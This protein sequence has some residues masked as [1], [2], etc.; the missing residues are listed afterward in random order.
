MSVFEQTAVRASELAR[1]ARMAAYRGLG[2]TPREHDEQTRRYFS[3]GR[4]Y[5]HY[6]C[7][8]LRAKH[9]AENVEEEVEIEWPLGVGHADAYIIPAKLLVEIKSTVTP[10]TSSP[11][12]EMAVAQL[13]IYLRYHPEAERG[14]L[15]LLNPSD[16]RG[17]DVFQ[18][19]LIEEDRERI[20]AAVAAVRNALDGG[21]LPPRVCSRPGQARGRLCPFAEPC[22]EDWAPPAPSLSS[23]PEVLEVVTRLVAIKAEERTHKQAVQGLAAGKELAQSELAELLPVGETV[24]GPWK[25]TR[26]HVQKQPVFQ[27][28]VARAAGF[29]VEALEEFMRPGAVYDLWKV[30]RAEESGDIDFGEEPPF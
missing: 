28:K 29:P 22:F 9:G 5:A 11:M 27:P 12:F 20:D 15:Y 1:C 18:V 13:Q 6:V 21:D 23:D 7:D 8:Q 3:R 4:L 10:S 30:G 2:V 17:E 26:T 25:V 14:A 24:V 16:L 19:V